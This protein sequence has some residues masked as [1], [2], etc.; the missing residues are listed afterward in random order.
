MKRMFVFDRKFANNADILFDMIESE[1]ETLVT[2]MKCKVNTLEATIEALLFELEKKNLK[3]KLKKEKVKKLIQVIE[4]KDQEIS[5]L[6][7]QLNESRPA[8]QSKNSAAEFDL[9]EVEISVYRM[10]SL[11]KKCDNTDAIIDTV[12]EKQEIIANEVKKINRIIQKIGDVKSSADLKRL[13]NIDQKVDLIC[14]MMNMLQNTTWLV[15]NATRGKMIMKA[16]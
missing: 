6:E 2:D 10:N 1:V 13:H 5:K 11:E 15:Q 12:L 16:I 7:S 9:Q 4:N 14:N 3:L 8:S